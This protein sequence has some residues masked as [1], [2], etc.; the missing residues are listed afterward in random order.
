MTQ[1]GSADVVIVGG[2]VV[3][4][5]VAAHLV[6]LGFRGRVVVVEPDPTYG[7]AATA[8]SASGI[9]RQFSNALNVRISAYG[10]EVIRALG[11]DFHEHGYLY[12][13]ATPAQEATLR[14]NHAT[15]LA[16]GAEVALL[17]PAALAARF[18]HL[19]TGDLRLAALGLRGEGWFDNMG[20]LAAFRAQARAGGVA[21]LRDRVARLD[22]AGGRVRGVGLASGGA[23][24]CGAL[25]NAAGGQG[26]EIAAL[27]GLALPVERRKRTVFAFEAAAPPAGRLPL[28][29]DPGGVWF[30]PE[31]ARFIAACAPDPDPAVAA[32]DF[33]PRHEEWEAVVWPAL[34]ARCRAFEAL[35]PGRFWAGHYDMNVLD[36]N[37]VV[38]PH[39]EVANFVFA[40]GFSGHGLQQAPAIGRGIAEWL[41]DGAYRSLDLTPL[42]Y[43]RIAAGAPFPE[44][45]VI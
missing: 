12:L 10:V 4:S 22:V 36:H 39:P 19:E 45:A 27:A 3:G 44:R 13:A 16:E 43:G 21:Y 18:P 31:G 32:D 15:Q 7:R 17:D 25:V 29:I 42:G 33:E 38:G 37:V 20:L 34:A 8:L 5:S 26:A 28:T 6:S 24:A 1:S 41:I 2:A 40:N 23:I 30:R 9:R 35:R 14:A 11:L